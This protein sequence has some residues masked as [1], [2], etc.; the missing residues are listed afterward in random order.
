MIALIEECLD[1]SKDSD[2]LN[3]KSIEDKLFSGIYYLTKDVELKDSDSLL[4]FLSD[5]NIRNIAKSGL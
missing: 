1:G 3:P 4:E 5:D 2:Y